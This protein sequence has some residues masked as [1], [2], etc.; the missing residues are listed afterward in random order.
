MSITLIAAMAKNRVIGRDNGLPWRLPD[1][2]KF[3]MRS[4]LGR[5]VLMGRRTFESLPGGPLKNRL[6]VVLTRR[7]DY[8][9]DGCEVVH[10]VEEALARY[11]GGELMVAGGAEVYALF[12]PHAD[13]ML[14]TEVDAAVEGDAFFPAWNPAEWTLVESLEHPADEKHA[15]AFR[16]NTYVRNPADLLRMR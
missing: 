3:F 13:R 15:Y 8:R 9:P 11:G 10:S 16:F 7:T 5:T 1:D 6:N 2:L 14:L 12:L 4:T